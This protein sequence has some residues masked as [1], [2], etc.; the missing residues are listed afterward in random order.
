[1]MHP[2]LHI[3]NEAAHQF[4]NAD[5]EIETLLNDCEF[6]EGP[7]WKEE[8][9][10]LFS[11]ISANVVY[12]LVP[13][14]QKEVFIQG[15]GTETLLDPDLNPDQIGSNGL[16]YD[17]EGSLLLCRHGGHMVSRWDGAALHP[18][19]TTYKDR[20]FNSPNDIIVDNK[21]RVFF[22][23]PPYGLKEGA[24]NAEKYQPLAGVYCYENGEITLVCDKYQYPNGVCITPDG[25]QLY[26]CSNK[27]FEKFI[28]IYDVETLQFQKILAEE[29]SDGIKCDSQGN[30][31]L[32]NKDGLLI[33]NSEGQRMALIQLPT[34]P[35]NHC[36]GGPA[37]KDLFITARQNVFRIRNLLH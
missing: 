16:A 1:M 22:S 34:I 15:S 9:Y 13:G 11:D 4:L 7:V 20:P 29:N 27:S 21:G 32:S 31:F 26:I 33:L 19:I 12:K 17:N 24:L 28:S 30:V 37:K 8:G 6:T 5:F 3:F 25:Q 23:D 2:S 10:Y 35:A 18:L 14:A 36:F